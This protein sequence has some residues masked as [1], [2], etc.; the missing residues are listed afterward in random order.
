M[1][2]SCAVAVVHT[3]VCCAD[4]NVGQNSFLVYMMILALTSLVHNSCLLCLLAGVFC[5][6]VHIFCS[7]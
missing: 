1:I 7:P 3:P 6:G 5:G 2:S 4:A